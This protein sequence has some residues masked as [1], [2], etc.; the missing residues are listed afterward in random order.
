MSEYIVYE[1]D[2][3][4]RNKIKQKL[5]ERHIKIM[6]L[7]TTKENYQFEEGKEYYL[8]ASSLFNYDKIDVSIAIL[9]KFFQILEDKHI[10]NIKF[11]IEKEYSRTLK[12]NLYYF[13]EKICSL[14]KKLNIKIETN[15]SI[16]E[17]DEKEF[18]ALK[19]EINNKIY[20][21]ESFKKRLIEEIENFRI[22]NK[23][24]MQAILSVF[25]FGKPG[26]GKT[27]TARVIHSKLYGQEDIIK[28]NFENYSGENAL[29]SLIGSPRG[30]IGSEHGE[31]SEKI[32]KSQSKIIIIDEFEKAS[33]PVFNFFLQLLEEGKFT[34]SLGR[35]YNLNEYVIYFTSN[36]E[37][38]KLHEKIS[39]E[40]FS[41]FNLIYKMTD[42]S[43]DTK[44]RYVSDR[45]DYINSLLKNKNIVIEDQKIKELK[46]LDVSQFEDLRKIN[47]TIRKLIG[48]EVY[49][50]F[51]PKY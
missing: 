20:G 29:S 45:I 40:L 35:E 16:V 19:E 15:K 30:Y 22:F 25:V 11:I 3:K 46:D 8:D 49:D 38:N 10:E 32:A 39:P 23:I 42:I 7:L 13:I 14:E 27:E 5:K 47:N 4:N 24:N 34:D 36:I 28:L 26:I 12:D 50:K 9:E 6:N 2:K 33:K 17:I 41:R 21:N 44:R 31:L 43:I 18:K 48:K 1:Y 37:A 51:H